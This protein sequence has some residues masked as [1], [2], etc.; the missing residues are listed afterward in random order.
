MKIANT[1]R[2]LLIRIGKT[3]PFV[4]CAI[5]FA[6]YL[7][8]LISLSL[9]MY[10]YY[11]DYVTLYK[12][13]SHA[14]GCVF[15]YDWIFI[16]VATILSFAVETCLY[17]KMSIAYLTFNLMEK[18]IF[19]HIETDKTCII[20]VCC[21]NMIISFLILERGLYNLIHEKRAVIN[22]N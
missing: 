6:S 4:I 16:A 12:P 17:N 13:F 1:A 14:V 15:E 10:V 5:V 20:A 18:H 3:L 7:E 8:S 21:A 22:S 2:R 9:G 11:D 19:E